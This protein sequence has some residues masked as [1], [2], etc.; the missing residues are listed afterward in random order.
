MLDNFTVEQQNKILAND[1]LERNFYNDLRDP[2]SGKKLELFLTGACR[3]NCEYCYLKKHQNVLYPTN[4]LNNEKII[5]NLQLVLN[6]YIENKFRCSIDIFSAEWLT[7]PLADDVFN[8]I[9]NT[10]KDILPEYR[11][12]SIVLADNMQFLKSEK[13]TEKVESYF[14]LMEQLGVPLYISASIDGK[15][16]DFGR[17]ENDDEFYQ[18]LK[19]FM[20]KHKILTHPMVSS[21]NI[22]YWIDN[23]VWFRQTFPDELTKDIMSLEVR[24]NTWDD[25]AINHLIRFCDFLVDYK[26]EE[27]QYDKLK[28]LKYIL[29]AYNDDDDNDVK[30]LTSSYNIIGIQNAG[31][32]NHDDYMSCSVHGTLPIRLGDLSVSPCHRL[33]YPE[34]EMGKFEVVD[35][36]ITEFIPTNVSLLI[37]MCH[38]RRSCMPKCEK[39][40]FQ[41]ICLGSCLGA[42]YEVNKNMF[43]PIKEVCKMY[44]AKNI[45]LIKKYHSLGLFEYLK[46]IRYLLPTN[47]YLYLK[48]LINDI[49]GDEVIC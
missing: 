22:K 6:W 39:C 2:A 37:L 10:F 3:A 42:N 14:T 44:S 46:D 41:D 1:V 16:C 13:Y 7:G 49:I 24:D 33:Y 17:T 27:L 9:Y 30:L 8:C 32:F 38:L 20:I 31:I 19:D 5:Q 45:F 4:L 25:E 35:N 36:K 43:V 40:K 34:F 11:P 18:K 29:R 48:D 21:S 15:Y 23:Y 28:M 47:R 12:H 26:F